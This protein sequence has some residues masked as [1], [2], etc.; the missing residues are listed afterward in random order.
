VGHF[1]DD[2][3]W[4]WDG[5]QWIATSQIVLPNLP[6]TEFERSG[7]L[8]E[9]RTRMRKRDELRKPGWYLNLGE[10]P[11]P[12]YGGRAGGS[13][14][15]V[16]HRA[17]RDYRLWTLEQLATATSYL[18][19]PNEQMQAAETTMFATY[20]DGV[21]IRDFGVVVTASRVLV[22]RI[23]SVDGQPRWVGLAAHPR[24]VKIELTSGWFGYG[25]TLR[26]SS[27][28]GQWAIRGYQRV[29]KPEPVLQAWHHA[30][31]ANV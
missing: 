13:S 30:A 8:S 29:F 20:F 27:R 10:F 24:D 15:F 3:E 17:F 6:M 5:K 26:V 16:Q 1:S 19:G 14:M 31:A 23:D 21:V 22:L 11:L 2:G 25:P 28:S 4:W 18:L 7:K 9:A 12:L